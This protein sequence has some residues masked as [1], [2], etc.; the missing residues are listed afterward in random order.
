[1]PMPM[2]LDDRQIISALMLLL[3]IPEREAR[4][5]AVWFWSEAGWRWVQTRLE[6]MAAH[7]GPEDS[8]AAWMLRTRRHSGV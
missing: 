4:H 8:R 7:G 1:M 6:E 3:E 2:P 5:L